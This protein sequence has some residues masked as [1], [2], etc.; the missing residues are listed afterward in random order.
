MPAKY[1][2]PG[3]WVGCLQT[4]LAVSCL[5]AVA[6]TAAPSVAAPAKSWKPS[7]SI[8]VREAY[9]SNV[10]MQRTTDRADQGAFV[11]GITPT[12]GLTWKPA[13][14][15]NVTASYAPEVSFYH[16][17]SSEDNVAHRGIANFSGK[18]E[19]V[20]YEFN[21]ALTFVNGDDLS[22]TY[23]GVGGSAIIGGMPLLERRDQFLVRQS[24]KVTVPIEKWFVRPLLTTYLH[25]FQTEHRTTAG[26]QN[27]VDRSDIGGG[28]DL[29]RSVTD[30]LAVFVGYRYGVQD[31][32]KSPVSAFQYD[33]TYHRAV[34]GVEGIVNSWLK[35]TLQAGPDFRDFTSTV[36]ATFDD[37]EVRLYLD[38]TVTLTLSKADA[39]NLTAKRF[40]LPGYGGGSLF[41][42]TTYDVSWKHKFNDKWSA[43][44]TGRAHNWDFAKPVVRDEW[45]Y[46][47][48]VTA[49]YTLNP[50]WSFDAGYELA[51]VESEISNT[52]GREATRHLVSLSA[53]YSF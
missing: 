41:E 9:D 35:L 15:F 46:G 11:T 22:P 24:L 45:W 36:P 44:L 47:A 13:D 25:D 37:D 18:L 27:Y 16:G 52:P 23:T 32:D 19:K 50:H 8:S 28:L 33:N 31:Q 29:G 26:Y 14:A 51:V 17:E 1:R 21:N 30:K 12:V 2:S 7:A 20:K 39:V 43:G 42:A 10:Y 38:G 34:V 53:R 49:T 40:V 48:G 3:G 5:S 4:V 6:Q